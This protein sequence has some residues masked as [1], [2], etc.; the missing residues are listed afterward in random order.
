MKK[1][2]I[3]FSSNI[4]NFLDGGLLEITSATIFDDARSRAE[5][6]AREKFTELEDEL[7]DPSMEFIETQDNFSIFITDEFTEDMRCI[8]QV[9]VR[10]IDITE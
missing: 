10:E 7:Q 3:D 2:I 9:T 4:N 8:Y 1:F 5:Y 6:I